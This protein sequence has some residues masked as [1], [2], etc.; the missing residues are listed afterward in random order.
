MSIFRNGKNGLCAVEPEK[1]S[2]FS[3]GAQCV[4]TGVMDMV[5][6]GRQSLADPLMPLKLMEGRESEI[7]YCTVCDNCLELLIQQSKV[8]CCTYDKR[9]TQELINTR[10]EKG[11]LKIAHT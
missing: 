7:H 4:D 5:G 3:Y 9:Y 8:G 2:L 1:S 11:K 6:L 10:K